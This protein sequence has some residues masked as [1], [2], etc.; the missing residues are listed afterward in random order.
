MSKMFGSSFSRSLVRDA[1]PVPRS[2]ETRIVTLDLD[3]SDGCNLGV[4]FESDDSDDESRSLS[5][6]YL[7]PV[8]L[9]P[10]WN[11]ANGDMAL[12]RWDRIVEVNGVRGTSRTLRR[13]CANNDHLRFLVMQT[14]ERNPPKTPTLPRRART[15]SERALAAT[16]A[17][18][19]TDASACRSG[20]DV[21]SSC[22]SG[23]CEHKEPEHQLAGKSYEFEGKGVVEEHGDEEQEQKKEDHKEEDDEENGKQEE[24]EKEE[25][26]E[27]DEE[28]KEEEDQ[29]N[30]EEER[31][32][33][34]SSFGLEPQHVAHEKDEELGNTE[35]E[36]VYPPDTNSDGLGKSVAWEYT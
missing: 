30:D 19:E 27:R 18:R 36:Q 11:A 4:D 6:D 14:R 24:H 23:P 28:E 10:S 32:A 13:V 15:E 8:G 16:E 2:R 26:K 1:S 7:H 20:P 33:T 34:R 22:A 29:E 31:K 5:I 9:I 35:P 25:E 12:R 17:S 21:T 3:G